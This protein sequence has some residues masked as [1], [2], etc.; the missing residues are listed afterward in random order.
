MEKTAYKDVKLRS[1]VTLMARKGKKLKLKIKAY[2]HCE[3]FAKE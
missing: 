2:N 3:R 1:S